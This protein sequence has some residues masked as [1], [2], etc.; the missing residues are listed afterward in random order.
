MVHCILS[1][2]GIAYFKMT[3]FHSSSCHLNMVFSIE[4]KVYIPSG[5]YSYS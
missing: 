4:G 1:V 5:I 3:A 2:D